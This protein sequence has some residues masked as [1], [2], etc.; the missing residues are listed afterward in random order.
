[1][2][3]LLD[4]PLS[5]LDATTRNH[6]SNKCIHGLLRRNP[7][8]AVIVA[9]GE[10]SPSKFLH[11]TGENATVGSSSCNQALE[12]SEASGPGMASSSPSSVPSTRTSESSDA[13]VAAAVGVLNHN[14]PSSFDR[15]VTLTAGLSTGTN[16]STAICAAFSASSPRKSRPVGGAAN[17]IE[18]FCTRTLTES[19][20][21]VGAN[22]SVTDSSTPSTLNPDTA[23]IRI[24]ANTATSSDCNSNGAFGEVPLSDGA[25]NEEYYGQQGGT[26]SR[27]KS[28]ADRGG[29]PPSARNT[30]EEVFGDSL[31]EGGVLPYAG[32][33]D[34]T[35]NSGPVDDEERKDGSVEFRVS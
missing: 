35:D 21:S 17:N 7:D 32:N 11:G 26:F 18:D 16:A 19:T 24:V 10:V 15:I 14:M 5:A 23:S 8:A 20:G 29:T 12:P 25:L 31:D 1:M 30:A 27:E 33:G 9:C 3:C 4:D 34:G 2:L 22:A 6:I 28:E 13:E